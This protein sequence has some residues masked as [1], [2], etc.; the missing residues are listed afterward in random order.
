M[1]KRL[2]RWIVAGLLVWL[3]DA[4]ITPTPGYFGST[5]PH[6][7]AIVST[8]HVYKDTE[9][10]ADRVAHERELYES[11]DLKKG[12]EVEAVEDVPPLPGDAFKVTATYTGLEGDS[13]VADLLE[14]VR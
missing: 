5:L 14:A 9:A 11:D 3:F 2:R 10:A 6:L 1:M 8:V 12:I 4:S 13:D 7:G